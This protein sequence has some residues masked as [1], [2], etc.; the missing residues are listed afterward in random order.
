METLFPTS[1]AAEKLNTSERTLERL[2]VTG[3]GPRFVKLGRLVRYTDLDLAAWI[4][5]RTVSST[6][7]ERYSLA[8]FERKTEARR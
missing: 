2:R 3:M 8:G 6:S 5:S 7:E 1:V 4:A